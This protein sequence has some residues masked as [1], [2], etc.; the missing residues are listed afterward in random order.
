MIAVHINK[1]Q[2]DNHFL[3]HPPQVKFFNENAMSTNKIVFSDISLTWIN[4]E[5]ISR[6]FQV[7]PDFSPIL[8]HFPGYPDLL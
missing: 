7:F 1:Q 2:V 5:K 3:K 4:I 6:L 8:V